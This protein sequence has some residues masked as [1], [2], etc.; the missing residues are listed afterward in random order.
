MLKRTISGAIITA[1]ML[2]AVIFSYVPFVFNGF[3]G[4]ITAVGMYEMLKAGGVAKHK[5]LTVC[6]VL[7][8]GGFVFCSAFDGFRPWLTAATV[9]LIFAAFTYYLKNYGKISLGDLIFALAMTLIV[10]YFFSTLVLVRKGI[11]GLWHLI[12]IFVLSWIPD[13]GAYLCGS[14][15]GKHKLAPVISPKKTIEGAVGGLIICVGLTFLYAWLVGS[16]AEGVSVNYWAVALY[17]VPG[18]LISILGDLTASLVKRHY[19][20]K[21]YGTLIPGHGGIMDRFDS[22]WFVAPFVWTMTGFVPVFF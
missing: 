22:I 20:I 1:V 4:L 6:S 8:A 17:A 2:I 14:A 18:T 7:F 9:L 19:G 13:T 5:V 12:L 16:Y 3:M 21:D 10:A 11:Q 15:F